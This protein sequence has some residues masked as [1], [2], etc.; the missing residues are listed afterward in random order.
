VNHIETRR[1]KGFFP[2]AASISGEVLFAVYRRSAGKKIR[3]RKEGWLRGLE[4]PTL[5][6]TR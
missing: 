5:R 2:L 6:S 3:E 4:P 1:M